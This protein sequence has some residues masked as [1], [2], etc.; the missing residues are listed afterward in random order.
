VWSFTGGD[1]ALLPLAVRWFD[2]RDVESLIGLIN[3][4]RRERS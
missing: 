1:F 2:V 4:I 3:L